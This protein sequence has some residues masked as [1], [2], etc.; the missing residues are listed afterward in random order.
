MPEAILYTTAVPDNA[1]GA[2]EGSHYTWKAVKAGGQSVCTR[3]T[4]VSGRPGGEYMLRCTEAGL[5][6]R[7]YCIRQGSPRRGEAH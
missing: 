1:G 4:R 5:D 7:P 2:L 3:E 6:R